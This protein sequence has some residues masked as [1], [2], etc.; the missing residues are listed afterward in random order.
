V[1]TKFT[2]QK[3]YVASFE[4]SSFELQ[5]SD[6]SYLCVGTQATS[7]MTPQNKTKDLSYLCMGP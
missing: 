5:N 7:C 6:L 4:A 2:V 3:V 1:V